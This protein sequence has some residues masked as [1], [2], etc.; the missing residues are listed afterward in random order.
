MKVSRSRGRLQQL[1]RNKQM[2]M[3]SNLKL[4]MVAIA[5]SLLVAACGGGGGGDDKTNS[6]SSTPNTTPTTTA[7]APVTSVPAPTYATGSF[8]ATA[9]A[10]INSYRSAMGVGMLKQDPIL[11]T[12]A[13]A[14][15]LYMYTNVRSGAISN[16]SHDELANLPAFY[17]TTP[18]ARAQKA[19]LPA[20]EWVG[21]NIAGGT[22]G[23]NATVDAA[24]CIG[25]ALASVYHLEAL[26]A[27]QESVGLGYA[28]GDASVPLYTCTTD[29]GTVTGVSGTPGPNSVTYTGGQA[30]ATTATAFSPFANE[31]GV[32]LAMRAE[33]P[34]PAPDV[35]APGRPILIRVNS[36][37]ADTLSVAEFTLTLDGT[38]VS[39]RILVPSSASSSSKASTVSDPNN[40]MPNGTA[41]LLPLAPLKA[42]AIYNVRFSGARDGVPISAQWSFSTAAQ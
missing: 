27:N 22:M 15:A 10:L 13:Q 8:A 1:T 7:V 17:A 16:I 3:K 6:T 24:D 33:S 36:Q 30:I 2:T 20:T 41:V 35:A 12:A 26:T 23:A 31:T 34:N 18:L 5:A 29:F 25:Q 11:D 19:G 28:S 4:S 38:P 42:N 9:F 32:A 39:A 37:A 40:L 14:H 21:E